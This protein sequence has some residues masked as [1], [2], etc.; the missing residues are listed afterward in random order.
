LFV[1]LGFDPTENMDSVMMSPS[2]KPEEMNGDSALHL[3]SLSLHG[4]IHHKESNSL[5]NNPF[6]SALLGSS[7]WASHGPLTGTSS[8]GS[9]TNWGIL[10]VSNGE[11]V[12]PSGESSGTAEK[13]A[14]SAT[15][16][17]ALSPLSVHPDS[18]TWGT[19]G[20]TGLG[21]T[22]MTNTNTGSTVD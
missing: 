3:E 9:L 15:S 7:T 1:G 6:G 17:L 20:L 10:G 18:Q 13:H 11:A 12:P 14:M 2:V 8:M 4:G 5:S 22:S 19:N 16:F 21:G